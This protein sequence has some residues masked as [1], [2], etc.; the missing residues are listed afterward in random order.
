MVKVN[1]Q[2]PV[3]LS[4]NCLSQ[5]NPGDTITITATTS[6]YVKTVVG[7]LFSNT[8]SPIEQQMTFIKQANDLKYWEMS[9][10]LPEDFSS[11]HYECCFTATTYNTNEQQVTQSFEVS[12]TE[13]IDFTIDGKWNGTGPVFYALEKVKVT[14]EILGA[15]DEV[16][17][18]LKEGLGDM[19]YH[20]PYGNYYAYT[21]FF[22]EN[23]SLP[24]SLEMTT[25]GVYV[26]EFNLPLVESSIDAKGHAL[27]QPYA[28]EL[29][30][31]TN[32]ETIMTQEQAIDIEGNIYDH[33]HIQE[34]NY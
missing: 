19:T 24:L 16:L 21:D 33:I 6:P 17:I 29:K 25:P 10:V 23:L 13:L 18:D 32:D 27:R 14:V 31:K 12:G 30:V 15:V 22:D 11:R 26:T 9:Y 34:K 7:E 2:T 20:D 1:V 28:I 8:E 5:Y 4:V 3:D